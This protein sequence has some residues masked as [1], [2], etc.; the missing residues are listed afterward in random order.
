MD[1]GPF[2]GVDCFCLD[3]QAVFAMTFLNRAPK[4]D[5]DCDCCAVVEAVVLTPTCVCV[6][7]AWCVCVWTGRSRAK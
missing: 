4:C 6:S 5:A 7:F 3:T 2:K 1:F